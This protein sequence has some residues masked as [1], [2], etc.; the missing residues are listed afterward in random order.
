MRGLSVWLLLYIAIPVNIYPIVYARRAW[1]VTAPGR[2]LMTKAIGNLILVDLIGAVVLFGDYEGRE[3]LRT[4]GSI[5]FGT[6]V[7]YLLIALL[8]TPHDNGRHS[9]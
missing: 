5:I 4:I 7:W 9:R 1:Y 2:A 6:G 8:R 3:L